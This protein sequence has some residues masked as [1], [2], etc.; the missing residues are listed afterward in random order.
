[1][2][3]LFFKKLRKNINIKFPPET[4]EVNFLGSQVKIAFPEI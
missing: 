2:M 3:N 1:M 4:Q